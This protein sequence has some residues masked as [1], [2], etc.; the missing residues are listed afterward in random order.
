LQIETLGEYDYLFYPGFPEMAPAGNRTYRF[1]RYG[2]KLPL[3]FTVKARRPAAP[4][5]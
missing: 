2:E 5:R 4:A 1:P 3:I